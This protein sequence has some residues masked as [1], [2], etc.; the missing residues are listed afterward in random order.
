[1][2]KRLYDRLIDVAAGPN[3]IWALVSSQWGGI[4]YNV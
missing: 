4:N 1:M 2:L 3:A